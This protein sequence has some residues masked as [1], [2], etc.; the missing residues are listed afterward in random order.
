MKPIA[1]MDFLDLRPRPWG[2][3]VLALGAGA[4]LLWAAT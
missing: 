3:V 1:Q 4:A 2:G